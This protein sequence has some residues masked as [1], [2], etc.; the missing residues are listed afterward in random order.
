M[1]LPINVN[2]SVLQGSVF[3]PVQ[4]ITYTEDVIAVS[5]KHGVG[6]HLYADAKQAY[7]EVYVQDI[8]K[9]R[10]TLQ[11]CI[12]DVRSWCS[13]RRLQLNTDKTELIWFGS[14]QTLDKVSRSDLTLQLDSGTI[15]LVEVVRDLGVLL[16]AELSIKQ[17]VIRIASNCFYQL[18]RQRQIRSTVGKEVTSQLISA[19]VLSQLDYCNS[20]LAGLPPPRT[21]IAPLQRVQ[22]AAVRLV[23]N[24]GFHDHLIPAL[25]QLHWLPVEYRIKYKLCALMHQI[26]TGRAPQYLV[27][28]VHSQSLNPAV[29][30]VN[31][32]NYVKR[33]IHTKIGERCFSHA[34]PAAWNSLPA[35]IK[36]TTDTNIFKKLLKSHLFHIAF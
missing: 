1:S 16:D 4:F 29:D 34:G 23:L 20:L 33:C 19:F 28:S 22:N 30:P 31:T 5:K 21:T 27:D 14:R 13:S 17:H 24:L 10:S 7:L 2:C 15:N 26:H 9:A 6:H 32:A 12:A 36:L 25:Q 35:S 3:G 11:E 18:R 8:D